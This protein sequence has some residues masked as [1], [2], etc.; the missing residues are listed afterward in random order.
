M[1]WKK[2]M[3][4][5]VPIKW[6]VVRDPKGELRT[7]AFFATDLKATENEILTWNKVTRIEV[8]ESELDVMI[9][10]GNGP[11]TFQLSMF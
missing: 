11:L 7:E 10:E 6:V 5:P 3:Q 9:K 2:F 1:G 8:K 4:Y